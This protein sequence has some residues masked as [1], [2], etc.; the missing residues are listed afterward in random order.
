V[1]SVRRA[2]GR[3]T[4]SARRPA[5]AG[6]RGTGAWFAEWPGGLPTSGGSWAGCSLGLLPK[7]VTS[8]HAAS[9]LRGGGRLQGSP[10]RSRR[11]FLPLR[12]GTLACRSFPSRGSI[13]AGRSAPRPCS[14]DESVMFQVRC[15]IW[16]TLSFHG[17][18]SPPR[19]RPVR[20]NLPGLS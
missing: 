15:R 4:P 18:G 9:H 17:L 14:T 16:N 7:Q 6:R 19:S 3:P 5:G 1:S 13:G 12:G 2:S 10:A 8:G 20:A 11:E